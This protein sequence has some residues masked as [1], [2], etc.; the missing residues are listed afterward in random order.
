MGFFIAWQAKYY[1]YFFQSL[2][3][4]YEKEKCELTLKAI[5]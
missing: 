3:Q 2:T 1:F 5:I 4:I